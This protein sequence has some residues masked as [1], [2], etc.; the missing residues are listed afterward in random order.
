MCSQLCCTCREAGSYGDLDLDYLT[1]IQEL[2][3][4]NALGI[5]EPDPEAATKRLEILKRV[6]SEAVLKT[7]PSMKRTNPLLGLPGDAAIKAIIEWISLES[8]C[9]LSSSA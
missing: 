6:K 1:S 8:R 5:K 4:G 3:S 7:G 9:P 2:E